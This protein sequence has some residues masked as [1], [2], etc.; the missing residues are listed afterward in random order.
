MDVLSPL[1]SDCWIVDDVVVFLWI[2]WIHYILTAGL[3]MW[4]RCGCG[5]STIF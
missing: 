3:L 5:E 4:L 1:H 2:W